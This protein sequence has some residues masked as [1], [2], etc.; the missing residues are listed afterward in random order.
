MD[1][2]YK[3]TT[4][5]R[6]LLAELLDTGQPLRLTRAAV[7]SGRVDEAED[8]AKV[9]SLIH[10]VASAAITER[11][12]EDDR[13]FLT[14]RYCNQEHP[15]VG[16][17]TLSEFAVW[18]EDPETGQETDFLYATLGDFRQPVPG[19]S[20]RFPASTWSYPLV[21][22]VSGEL[23]VHITASPGLVTSADLQDA[24]DRLKLE[25]MINEL[26]LPLE[27]DTG[28][29]LLTD[30]GTPIL[31]VYRPNQ[32][33]DILTALEALDGRLSGQIGQ[34]AANC[35]AQTGSAKQYAVTAAQA[36]TDGRIAAMQRK[37]EADA[38]TVA[39]Q[40]AAAKQEAIDAASADAAAQVGAH[41]AAAASH[42]DFLRVA[43]NTPIPD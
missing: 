15:G 37:M 24:I 26:T 11:R 36:Y 41:N 42:A 22:A 29:Q 13:M 9:H 35:A 40:I 28:E 6:Q 2:G 38:G 39:G 12:H 18:A 25:I 10:P 4:H 30:K 21:L 34:V 43:E 14:V 31:A 19:Y 27:T 17:F 33:A 3:I 1:Y 32:S 7:G 5:G 8:L 16:T 20:D 23:E